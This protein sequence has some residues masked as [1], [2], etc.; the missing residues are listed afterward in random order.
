GSGGSAAGRAGVGRERAV[1]VEEAGGGRAAAA[2]D[3]PRLRQQRAVLREAAEVVLGE[4]GDVV[5]EAPD[6]AVAQRAG[7]GEGIEVGAGAV[8]G[9]RPQ[10]A[11]GAGVDVTRT[12]RL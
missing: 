8:V 2:E 4:P 6:A 1:E 7:R 9:D 11:A 12:D 10:G 5:A 3:Q